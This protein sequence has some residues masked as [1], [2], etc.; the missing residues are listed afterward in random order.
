MFELGLEECVGVYHGKEEH[1]ES[2]SGRSTDYTKTLRYRKWRGRGGA[3]G[4]RGSNHQ[5]PKRLVKMNLTF[6]L[7]VIGSH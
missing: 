2:V 3:K 6:T 7:W 5:A 1:G 4:L